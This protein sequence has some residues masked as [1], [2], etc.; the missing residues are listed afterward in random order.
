MDLDTY[1]CGFQSY[2]SASRVP[3]R[4]VLFDIHQECGATESAGFHSPPIN[5]DAEGEWFRQVVT[6]DNISLTFAPQPVHEDPCA[7]AYRI[8]RDHL[9]CSPPA[10]GIRVALSLLIL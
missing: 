10:V 9:V 7:C 4:E 2:S 1:I 8:F 3:C 5:K 6:Q